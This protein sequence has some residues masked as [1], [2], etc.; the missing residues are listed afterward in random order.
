[1]YKGK[2]VII[3]KRPWYRNPIFPWG[4]YSIMQDKIDAKIIEADGY[5]VPD[6]FSGGQFIVS[7]YS[8]AA[9][10]G[11]TIFTIKEDKKAFR[12]YDPE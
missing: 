7:N 3:Q 1:M 11:G 4:W 5:Y 12:Q 8:E 2:K 9:D 6:G 10:N